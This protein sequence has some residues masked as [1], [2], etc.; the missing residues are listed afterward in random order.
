[1]MH[2]TKLDDSPMF[3]GQVFMFCFSSSFLLPFIIHYLYMFFL[4]VRII[5]C[6]VPMLYICWM[7]HAHI[8]VMLLTVKIWIFI[9]WHLWWSPCYGWIYILL[10]FHLVGDYVVY[11]PFHPTKVNI[12][13]IVCNWLCKSVMHV[14]IGDLWNRASV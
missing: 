6:N 2:F 3:R 9:Y 13:T 1:M 8:Y 11:Y 10:P 14:D 12:I 5:N 4:I 7:L